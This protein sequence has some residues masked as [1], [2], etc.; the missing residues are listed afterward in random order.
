MKY[1]V[2]LDELNKTIKVDLDS[3]EASGSEK[4]IGTI[5]HPDADDDLG[6]RVNHVLYQHLQDLL[7]KQK[8][9]TSQGYV[10]QWPAKV[11]ATAMEAVPSPIKGTAGDQI[12]LEISLTPLGVADPAITFA[13]QD[14]RFADVDTVGN[15]SLFKEG[16]TNIRVFHQ[17]SG[18]ILVVPVIIAA[19]KDESPV[20]E[21]ISITTGLPATIS[22]DEGSAI[23][24]P[25]IV[26]A[27]GEAPYSYKYEKN[28]SLLPSFTT[29]GPTSITESATEADAG[30]YKITV[31]D[32][33]SSTAET[34]TTVSVTAASA[35]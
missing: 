35:P 33:N 30:T 22:V 26:V 14:R 31:T 34:S 12:K 15:V 13:S 27:G 10:I 24:L 4:L 21:P 29:D 16:T 18:S 11:V 5:D 6:F 25:K 23:T 8:I 32:A 3:A 19:K 9:Y 1:K 28:G 17:P 2:F 7:Y 20:V